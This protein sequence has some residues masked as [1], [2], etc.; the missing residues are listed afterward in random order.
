MVVGDFNVVSIPVLP[1]EANSPLLVDPDA[2]LSF[3]VA[4]KL[5]QTVS[6]RD[7]QVIQSERCVELIQ[8]HNGPA[9]KLRRKFPG[10]FPPEYFFCPRI[11][12]A[13]DHTRKL[14]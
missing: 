8:L 1:A 10:V 9:E 3:P 11:C 13:L 14:P 2:V 4:V 5:F 6:G 7:T 12:E